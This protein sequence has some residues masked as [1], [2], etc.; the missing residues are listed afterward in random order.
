M[1]LGN[2]NYPKFWSWSDKCTPQLYGGRSFNPKGVGNFLVLLSP[3]PHTTGK[4]VLP[5]SKAK[6]MYMKK[7]K[8]IV[9]ITSWHKNAK[10]NQS[11]KCIVLYVLSSS[12]PKTVPA[13]FTE[14]Q[15]I[16][17][18]YGRNAIYYT[19]QKATQGF[20]LRCKQSKELCWKTL[21]RE[22]HTTAY[23]VTSWKRFTIPRLE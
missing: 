12:N 2:L 7:K 6:L 9:H 19:M 5:V 15:H 18:W 4:Y 13:Y 21:I 8:G 17:Q 11:K 10:W 16:C 23:K 20:P 3:H 22:D 14:L 1:M